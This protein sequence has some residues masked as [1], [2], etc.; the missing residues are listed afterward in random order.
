M[1][2]TRRTA[3]GLLSAL[4]AG[5]WVSVTAQSATALQRCRAWIVPPLRPVP[6]VM[7]GATSWGDLAVTALAAVTVVLSRVQDAA[8]GESL[9]S[10]WNFP[11]FRLRNNTQSCGI[12]L[13]SV[14]HIRRSGTPLSSSLRA[15]P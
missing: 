9:L 15:N 11:C 6:R 14:D 3:W 4:D 2:A 12:I 13:M 5:A 8:A 1:E 10:S 7:A